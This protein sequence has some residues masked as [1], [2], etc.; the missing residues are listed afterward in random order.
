MVIRSHKIRMG[1][2]GQQSFA[3]A[4]P[5]AQ[6]TPQP[7]RRRH[8]RGRIRAALKQ[9]GL[10]LLVAL[11]PLFV[12]AWVQG[13]LASGLESATS[14]MVAM[15][16]DAGFKVEMVRASGQV[17]TS[18]DAIMEAL[19]VQAGDPLFA[20]D[21]STLGGRIEALPWVGKASVTRELPNTLQIWIN[22]RTPFVRW[23]MAG[24]VMLV[25]STGMKIAGADLNEFSALPFVVGKGAPEAA[26]ALIELISS[27]EALASRVVSAIRVG[28]RRWDLE[29]D[30]GMRLKLPEV[31]AAYGPVEAWQAFL[32]VEREEGVMSMMVATFDLRLSDRVVMRLTPEGKKIFANKDQRT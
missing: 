16:V 31:G 27:N 25:D 8:R 10:F 2:A 17:R 5:V 3:F 30:N 29:F 22:E 11:M 12:W 15:S 23:Q 7:T 24:E 9:C 6:P 28:Q 19:G 13:Y 26:G 21:M 4:R 1:L 18:D 32:K 14:K 20:L